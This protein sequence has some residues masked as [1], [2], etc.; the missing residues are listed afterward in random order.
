MSVRP[1]V[2]LLGEDGN[3]LS[4]LGKTI[5]AMTDAG[6]PM[7]T[8]QD[9]KKEAMAGDYDNLLRVTMEYVEVE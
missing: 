6:V 5:R 7:E 8:V 9:Y 1:T 4:I 2:K 3:A